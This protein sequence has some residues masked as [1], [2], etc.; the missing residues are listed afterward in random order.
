MHFRTE[1]L[2]EFAPEFS[3]F[4]LPRVSADAES[5]VMLRCCDM[6]FDTL[7]RQLSLQ[8]PLEGHIQQH[9]RRFFQAFSAALDVSYVKGAYA[10][11][12][13]VCGR[14]GMDYP[15]VGGASIPCSFSE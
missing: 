5:A 8:W 4:R 12:K 10:L 13:A 3:S 2:H 1:S 11:E 9:S 6:D 14:V 15:R 7:L